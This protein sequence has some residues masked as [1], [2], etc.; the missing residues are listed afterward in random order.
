MK[1][2]ALKVLSLGVVV[3]LFTACSANEEATGNEDVNKEENENQ[4]VNVDKEESYAGTYVGYSWGGEADGVTLEEAERK[5][6]TEITLDDDGVITDVSSL[7]LHDDG[8]G[9]WF[10]RQDTDADVNVDFSVAPTLAT[11]ENE[12]QEYAAGDSMFEI[13]TANKMSFYAL[14][15]NEDGDVA[16]GI[17]EPYTRYLFEYKMDSDFDFST[18]MKDMTIG[19]GLAVPTVRTSG[20]GPEGWDEDDNLLSF[21]LWGDPITDQGVFEGLDKESSMKEFLE[22]AG[23]EFDGDAPAPMELTYDFFGLGGWEGNY[24]AIE[25]S[26]IGE[27]AT[28]LTSLIDWDIDRYNEGIN[29]DNFFGVDDVSGATRTVQDSMD[30]ISGAT[31]RV[32][33]ESTAYQRALVEAGIISEED[34]IKGR[35]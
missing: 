33:R 20:S 13:D 16:F 25:E 18:P 22:N 12:D 27:N 6:E 17:V 2:R 9:S 7:Y 31:V 23:V 8:E 29:D 35:F 28:E 1:V 15:V 24:K 30:G 34:V 3:S 11:P 26:L 32:T 5:I 4:E 10:A 21:S 19:S 14:T